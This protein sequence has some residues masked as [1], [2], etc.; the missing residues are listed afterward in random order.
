MQTVGRVCGMAL[1]QELHRREN[2]QEMLGAE[3]A[4]PPLLGAVLARYFVRLVQHNPPTSLPELQAELAAECAESDPDYR[5]GSAILTRSLAE[6]GLEGLSF[7]RSVGGEE[8]PL[9]EGGASLAV[10]EQNKH[11]W[12]QALLRAEL[13]DSCAA[14]ATHFRQGLLDV[15]G[16]SPNLDAADANTAR[17]LTPHLFLLS[18]EELRSLWS[19]AVRP[20]MGRPPR[21]QWHLASACSLDSCSP[22]TSSSC[23][24][25]TTNTPGHSHQPHLLL[26]RAHRGP[27]CV[28]T[29]R[30]PR[31]RRR[32]EPRRER[33]RRRGDAGGVAVGG[34]ARARRRAAR[35]RLPLRHRLVAPARRRRLRLP[36]RAARGR[37]R[38]VPLR[39][40]VRQR[41][42]HAE[43]LVP[44]GDAPEARGGRGGGARQVYRP[45][46]WRCENEQSF[47]AVR[48]LHTMAPCWWRDLK[49]GP[50]LAVDLAAVGVVF[51]YKKHRRPP[52][53]GA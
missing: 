47:R 19:G 14:A 45:L 20:P 36:D 15:I 29:A 35:A 52:R 30:Q 10:T 37:R 44:R 41:P 21:G 24:T 53:G 34:D 40:R 7:V 18:A 22:G 4:P 38:R 3:E 27:L 49:F 8:V 9:V 32:A 33:A 31:V 43:L 2:L 51:G 48:C 39:P 26:T 1:Y 23:S 50:K 17:W 11:T 25:S 12:L 16:V 46:M 5:A 28:G 6:S 42:R 13:L